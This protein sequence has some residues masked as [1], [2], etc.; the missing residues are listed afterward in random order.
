VFHREANL[1]ALLE[2]TKFCT[3][4][5]NH[6]GHSELACRIYGERGFRLSATARIIMVLVLLFQ[7]RCLAYHFKNIHIMYL[8][9]GRIKFFSICISDSFFNSKKHIEF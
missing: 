5:A 3:I 6:D 2:D 8:L 9:F 7:L 1:L 4:Y